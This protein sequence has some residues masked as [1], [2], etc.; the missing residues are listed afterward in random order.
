MDSSIV[1]GYL[2]IIVQYLYNLVYLYTD[3]PGLNLSILIQFLCVLIS[4]EIKYL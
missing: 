4:E 3:I 2:E 1:N